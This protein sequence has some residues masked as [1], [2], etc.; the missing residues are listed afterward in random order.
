MV[1]D[2]PAAAGN[3]DPVQAA[4]TSMRRPITAGCTE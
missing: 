2:G 1:G 4:M 3:A